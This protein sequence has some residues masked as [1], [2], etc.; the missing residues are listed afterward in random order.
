MKRRVTRRLTRFQ[1]MY[2]VLKYRK[3]FLKEYVRLRFGP[4]YFLSIL[5][6]FSVELRSGLGSA[7]LIMSFS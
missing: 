4:G 7:L 3:T 5:L 6:K 1:T 2:K